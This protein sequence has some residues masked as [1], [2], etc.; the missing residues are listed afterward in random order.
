MIKID[1]I[2]KNSFRDKN[3][4]KINY[5]ALWYANTDTYANTDIYLTSRASEKLFPRH[6][7]PF[8]GASRG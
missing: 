2:K 3:A 7:R 5:T 8:V 6:V 1:I 4:W